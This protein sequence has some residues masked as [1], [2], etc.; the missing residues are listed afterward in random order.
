MKIPTLEETNALHRKYAPTK[1]AYESVWK[2]SHIVRRIALQIADNYYSTDLD[3]IQ[4]GAMLH[5][6]GVYRLYHDGELDEKNYI[7]HGY[8]GYKF[9]KELG[10]DEAICRFALLHTGVGISKDDVEKN[11]LPLPARDYFAETDEEKI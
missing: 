1:E 2:H 7:R 9:L 11:K 8:L 5:D 6:I 3:L 10:F 4:A